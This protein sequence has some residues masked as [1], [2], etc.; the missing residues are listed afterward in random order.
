MPIPQRIRHIF[1][2]VQWRSTSHD[3]DEPLVLGTLLGL[4]IRDMVKVSK[5]EKMLRLI[6]ILKWFPTDALFFLEPRLQTPKFGWSISSYATRFQSGM[7]D[8]S[9][10]LAFADEHGLHVFSLGL[11]FSPRDAKGTL[12]G[13][14]NFELMIHVDKVSYR[15]ESGFWLA[16]RNKPQSWKQIEE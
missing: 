7:I 15:M 12:V 10:T 2:L 5:E 3:E 1:S 13:G 8:Q 14:F 9:A 11:L 4:D 16:D 6:L